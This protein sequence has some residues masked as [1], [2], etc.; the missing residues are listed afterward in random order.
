MIN[1]SRIEFFVNSLHLHKFQISEYSQLERFAQDLNDRLS[2]AELR[3]H[4]LA[5]QGTQQ[6]THDALLETQ[7]EKA[8]LESKIAQVGVHEVISSISTLQTCPICCIEM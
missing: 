5:N 2:A 4:Q 6:D 7:E 1:C 8:D 3:A